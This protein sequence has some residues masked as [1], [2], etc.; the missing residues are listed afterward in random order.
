MAAA[1]RTRKVS[2]KPTIKTTTEGR[3]TA[4]SSAQANR[5]DG[6]YAASADCRAT[7][8]SLPTRLTATEDGPHSSPEL[9]TVATRLRATSYSP[10]V[11]SA[12]P[13][14]G[15]AGAANHPRSAVNSGQPRTTTPQVNPP[16][17]W[18]C[19]RSDLAYNDE[20]SPSCRATF[21]ACQR[22][23]GHRGRAL[24]YG[25]GRTDS[26]TV[27]GVGLTGRATSMPFTAVPIGTQRS[28]TDNTQRPRPALFPVLAGDESVRSGFAS[29]WSV[30]LASALPCPAGRSVP[31][32]GGP[33]RR[34]RPRPDGTAPSVRAGS[35]AHR[36]HRGT[37]GHLRS[38]TA[39][40]NHRSASLQ[41]RQLARR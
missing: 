3:I 17:R 33:E 15:R 27:Y 32:R 19:D 12:C 6:A 26:G 18:Q 4:H 39:K 2:R 21:A 7:F 20:V 22:G 35:V 1:P 37:S 10:A 36:D 29:R 8:G 34:R 9:V 25:Q 38:P 5:R 24:P 28:T 23:S 41:V 30:R 11:P 13:T 31:G 16:V 14:V 40:R